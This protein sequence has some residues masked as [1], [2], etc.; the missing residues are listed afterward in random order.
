MPPVP[1]LIERYAPGKGLEDVYLRIFGE[2]DGNEAVSCRDAKDY[3]E[4]EP[5]YCCLTVLVFANLL[6]LWDGYP[7]RRKS[8]DSLRLSRG[9]SGVIWFDNGGKGRTVAFPLFRRGRTFENGTVFFGNQRTRIL[10]GW[11]TVNE[12]KNYFKNMS[13]DIWNMIILYIPAP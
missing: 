1:T 5:F 3:G 10:L 9:S 8:A 4:T 11:D 12:M 2:E 7:S 6:L 13:S